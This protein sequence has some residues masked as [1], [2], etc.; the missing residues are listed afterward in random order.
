MI[1]INKILDI[2]M[3]FCSRFS[4]FKKIFD[5][6]EYKKMQF[7]YCLLIQS[8]QLMATRMIAIPVNSNSFPKHGSVLWALN[9]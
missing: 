7:R 9:V 4:N 1:N 2:F 8:D 6:K 3:G 5:E